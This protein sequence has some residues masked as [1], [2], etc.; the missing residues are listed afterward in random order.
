[1]IDLKISYSIE[2]EV[3]RISETLRRLNWFKAKGYNVLFPSSLLT[4]NSMNISE[5]KIK[6]SVIA[7]Y[8]ESDYK[9]Q[10][11]YLLT[12]WNDVATQLSEG[13]SNIMFV[14]MNHYN[15]FLSKYGV[16]G[17]YHYPDEIIVN[18]KF[19]YEKGLLRTTAHEIIH[20]IIQPLIEKYKINH[21]SKERVVDLLMLKLLPQLS[22]P[23]Q[24]PINTEQIDNIFN[25]MYPDVEA[26]IKDI[27]K[28]GEVTKNQD[29]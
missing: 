1:M 29:N 4:S 21:W 6:N 25:K 28:L 12:N 2:F 16:A 5:E 18:I 10:K 8:V 3:E 13:L 17:S 11:D 7:E 15:I 19:K 20:L 24:L 22:K 26:V 23:Q 9:I 27:G 14:P